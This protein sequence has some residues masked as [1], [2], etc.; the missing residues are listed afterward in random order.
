MHLYLTRQVIAT[1]LMTVAVF[2]FVLLLGNGLKEIMGL[3]VNGQATVSGIVEAF[4]LLIPFVL[5]FALPMGMLTAT[6]LVFG[7]FSADNELTAV[8]ASGV[9]LLTL[10][11][12]VLVLSVVLSGFSAWIN[13]EVAPRSRVA[14]KKITSAMQLKAISTSIPEGRYVKANNE[15]SFFVGYSDGLFLH[16]VLVTRV[17]TNQATDMFIHA[18]SGRVDTTNQTLVVSL[19]K[20][21]T[22]ERE[23]GLWTSGE[24][25]KMVLTVD[26]ADS[27]N[28]NEEAIKLSDMTFQQ[29]Q[30]E[31]TNMETLFS[32]PPDSKMTH[33]QWKNEQR[34]MAQYKLD[35][36]SRIM[37]EMHREVA[38]SLACFGFSLVGIP[39]AIRAHRRETNVGI[40]MALILVFIYYAFV[41]IGQ[42][43]AGHPNL[44]PHLILWIP[45]FLFQITGAILLYKANRGI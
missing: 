34:V 42:S 35:R 8:R 25:G 19:F 2:T 13:M 40:F 28:K 36:S 33:D 21:K 24:R 10:I 29:L 37:V 41:V 22:M 39:L 12:P 38:L 17:D 43:L 44:A 4:G 9:S 16:D 5:V 18:E 31:L 26:M 30:Q 1:L 14:Y 6:L 23:N 3:L 45:N 20:A 15:F 27:T 7:R 32:L 11:S